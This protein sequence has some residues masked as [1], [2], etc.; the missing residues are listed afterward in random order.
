MP[1]VDGLLD[2]LRA[3]GDSALDELVRSEMGSRVQ[4]AVAGLPAEQR[5]VIVLRYTQGLSYD[6][7]AEILGCSTGTVASR[8]NRAH[9]ILGR[10]LGGDRV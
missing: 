6:E 10:R 8:L 9:K 1:L 4:A 3:P 5:I 7:I 2:A